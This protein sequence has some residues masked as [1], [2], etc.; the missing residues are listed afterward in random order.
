MLRFARLLASVLAFAACA[1]A[2]TAAVPAMAPKEA[3]RLVA[4]GEAVLVDCREAEEWEAGV[5]APA[6]LL[7]RS[8]FEGEQKQWRDFLA[9]NRDRRIILYCA[10]GSRSGRLAAKLAAQGLKT[11][12]AGS[13]V[14]WQAAGLPVRQ[15]K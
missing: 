13:F 6:V 1:T 12:N 5:A 7:P 10:S 8:D 4:A 2:A 11:A 9:Q 14:A 3:A 15:P